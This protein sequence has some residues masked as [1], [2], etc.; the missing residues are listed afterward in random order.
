VIHRRSEPSL[1]YDEVLDGRV[2]QP[3]EPAPPFDA[4]TRTP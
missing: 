3:G 2:E 1:T 4:A